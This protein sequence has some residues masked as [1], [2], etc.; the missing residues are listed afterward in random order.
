MRVLK[1]ISFFVIIALT[2]SCE[3]FLMENPKGSLTPDSFFQSSNDLDLALTS[4]YGAFQQINQQ[5][6]RG[7][8]AYIGDDITAMDA[9]NKSRFA[10]FDRF[11]YNSGNGELVSLYSALW[12]TV[13]AANFVILNG[14]DTP[15]GEEF[16]NHRVG[17]AYFIRAYTYFMLVRLFGDVPIV[18]DISIDFNKQRQ[19]PDVVY[20]FILSDIDEAEKRLPLFHDVDPYF[21]NGINVAPGEGAVKALKASVFMTMAGWPLKKGE[22]WYD[23]AAEI[24]QEIIENEGKYGY[25]LEPDI[26]DL[27]I[28]PNFKYS[29]EI[30][31]GA[32]HHANQNL[33]MG[34]LMELPEETRG[35]SDLMVEIEFY[36]SMPDGPRKD[37]WIL[38]EVSLS[39]N[40]DPVTG[41]AR[42]V[43]W[44]SSETNQRHP[45]WRKNIDD[46][47]WNYEQFPDG[48]IYYD[49][50]SLPYNSG[51]TRMIIRYADL[52]LLYAEA[53][54]FGS[55]G[56]DALAY[57]SLNR[58]RERAGLDPI[59]SGSL[60][61]EAFQKA[62]LDER[63][64]ETAGLEH[65]MMG[66]FF[67]M[68][69]HEILEDQV[70]YRDPGDTTI[71]PE[72]VSD[73]KRFYYLPIPDQESLIVPDF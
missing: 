72:F 42:M 58:V 38:S 48:S 71:N 57:E 23:M 64:W 73:P 40:R 36:N 34:P 68:Q 45:Y 9:G 31:F 52:L 22:A 18:D 59:V 4:M 24:F 54:A 8:Y 32:F 10:E 35:W 46:G 50:A 6:G 28:V 67:T 41:L 2:V 30:V 5:A 17:Q 62:V 21:Q 11:Y 29:K 15:G 26:I 60:S 27:T 55:S 1:L 70:E 25:E 43:P 3:D 56:A 66:R 51:S 63:R 53:R 65:S 7:L 16:V 49:E 69:R 61:K 19:S 44:N 37:A 47:T 13:K 33:F 20:D 39:G 14:E 12:S